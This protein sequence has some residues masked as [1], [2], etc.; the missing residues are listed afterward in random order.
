MMWINNPILKERSR[1]KRRAL[2]FAGRRILEKESAQRSYACMIEGKRQD[3]FPSSK[4][5][6]DATS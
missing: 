3:A 1:R 4:D 2:K 5:K 6:R